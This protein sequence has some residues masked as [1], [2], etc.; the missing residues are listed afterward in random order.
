[1]HRSISNRAVS[2]DGMVTALLGPTNT[3]KTYQAVAEMLNYH[4]GIMG[5]PLRLLARENYD[6]VVALK[7]AAAVALVTGEEKIVP[8]TAQYFLCTVEA[9]P[10][11]RSF[12]FLAVDEIQLCADPDRGHIFTD[13]LL[14]ARGKAR[15]MFM[16]ADTIAPLLRSLIPDIDIRQQARFSQ[17]T[18]T[19]FKK[20]TRLP[21]RTA[22]VAFTIN[23]LYDVADMIRRQRGG[24]AVVLGALSPRTRNAQVE[25]YQSGEVDFMVATDAIGMGL[26]MDIHHI[27]FAATRKFDGQQVRQLG[28]AEMGQIAGRAGRHTRDGTFGVTGRVTDLDD[29]MVEAIETHRFDTLSAL[30]WRNSALDFSSPKQLLRTLEMGSGSPLLAKGWPGDD[31]QALEKLIQRDD[32]M[33]RT[34][35]ET[36]V[37]LLWDVCQIPDFRK[38]L[39]ESHQ[40]LLAQVYLYLVSGQQVLPEDWVAAQIARLD[41]TEGDVDTLMNRIAHIRTWTYIAYRP[42]WLK[43]PSYWQE[44]TRAIE[45]K[46]SDA[47]HEGL[48]RRFVDRRSAILSKG[49]G[50]QGTLLGGVR[51]DG[52]LV[53]EGHQV[54]HLEGFRF[55][56]DTTVTGGDRKLIFSVARSILKPEIER[57][58]Q[59]IL[60]AQPKQFSLRDDGQIYFQKDPTNPLPGDPLARL[61]KGATLLQPEIELLNSDLLEGQDKAAV[62]DHVALW[63]K[64]HIYSTLEPLFALITDEAMPASARGIAFQVFEGTGIIPRGQVEDLIGTL[65]QEGRQALRAKKVKLGPLLIFIPDL[66]KPAAVRLRALMWSLFN[67]QTLPAPVPRDGA[68]SVVVD[69]ATANPD[70][71]RAIGYPVYGN[72]AVRIDMLDRVINS[73]YDSAKDGKFQAQHAQAEWMGVP[74]SDLYGILTAMGHR[75]IIKSEEATPAAPAEA[76]AETIQPSADAA[77]PEAGTIPEETP[78]VSEGEAA[79]PVAAE[80]PADEAPKPAAKPELDWF[81]LRRGKAHAEQ[82]ARAPRERRVRPKFD[83]KPGQS[84]FKKGGDDKKV[85][86]FKKKKFNRDDKHERKEKP[87]PRVY[88]AEAKSEDNPFAVLRNLNLK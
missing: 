76:Q 41:K 77:A 82:A 67:D 7:G 1:M 39:S 80:A 8:P 32:I 23:D 10:L 57:R 61:K 37:R 22:I 11:D 44:I 9:M 28:T 42:D 85:S 45:D 84:T 2:Y 36:R 55:I 47:L 56:P 62:S 88:K 81:F 78:S 73:I 51:S 49:R 5:F 26:N 18:Y 70:F 63:L 68:M 86:D 66:N 74:I 59:M 46:L 79:A 64:A 3:G 40:E 53:V 87:E 71:Y 54:G 38:I 43:R 6:R 20:L 14:N 24:T 27:A 19:G 60:T 48:L 21:P 58:I 13:R 17:L 75:H 65:D 12:E 4:S 35:A 83:K 34:D 69:P 25:M 72:R 15:T 50:E 30:C 52:A 16:G 33:A 29:D 31:L